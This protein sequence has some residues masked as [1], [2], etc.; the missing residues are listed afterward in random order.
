MASSTVWRGNAPSVLVGSVVGARVG[1]DVGLAVGGDVVGAGVGTLLQAR[2]T[3]AK[4]F[5]LA[6]MKA[7]I[8]RFKVR[9]VL[10]LQRGDTRHE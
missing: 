3:P 8:Q 5:Q 1:R 7:I 9:L 6:R 10:E 2:T 4:L